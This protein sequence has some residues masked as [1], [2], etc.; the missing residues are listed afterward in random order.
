MRRATVVATLGIGL[1]ASSAE[2]GSLDLRGGAF[3]PRAE[4]NLFYDDA[5]LYLRDGRPLERSDWNNAIGGF[6]YNQ[7]LGPLV[8]LGF[9]VDFFQRTLQT[10]YRDFVTSTDRE[11]YQTLQLNMVPVG[12]QVRLGPTR[13][14]QISPYLAVGGDLVYYEYEEWGDFVDFDDPANPIIPDS[15]IS[16]GVAPGFHV[17]GGVR[18]PVGDDFAITAEGRYQWAE[19][20]MGDDFRGNRIDLTGASV[21]VGLNIRF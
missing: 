9:S 10:S 7:E 20:D 15:F 18:V 21:T 8:E 17:A 3:F 16:Q 5:E 11:I 1:L 2:A 6:Q 4:S 14:G 12:V 19:D 13:R